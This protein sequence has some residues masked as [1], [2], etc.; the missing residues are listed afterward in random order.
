M[1][2]EV[3]NILRRLLQPAD[4]SRFP[5]TPYVLG[6]LGLAITFAVV[7]LSNEQEAIPATVILAFA[8]LVAVMATIKSARHSSASGPGPRTGI[9]AGVSAMLLVALGAMVGGLVVQAQSEA[10]SSAATAA[11]FVA[12]QRMREEGRH[13]QAA[14]F[15]A[16]RIDWA[17]ERWVRDKDEIA[18]NPIRRAYLMLPRKASIHESAERAIV[19]FAERRVEKLSGDA[20]A[21]R[22][23][24]QFCRDISSPGVPLNFRLTESY[25]A[26]AAAYSKL[27]GRT[28]SPEQ[29]APA[30]P[31]G[32]CN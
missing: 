10:E 24:A 4:S 22:V 8:C 2:G 31:G 7:A 5:R 12:L 29:L 11:I 26:T 19:R 27:L 20:A 23:T 25:G 6:A 14:Y 3:V 30:V 17:V 18:R 15:E 1:K 32:Y 9:F 16:R 21:W 13:G 28:I